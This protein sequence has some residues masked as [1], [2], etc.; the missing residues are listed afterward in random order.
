MGVATA[1]DDHPSRRVLL[2]LLRQGIPRSKIPPFARIPDYRDG[3][4]F[5]DNLVVKTRFRKLF[6]F[7][8]NPLIA[9][10]VQILSNHFD[11]VSKLK[12]KNTAVPQSMLA[13]KRLCDLGFW[14][15][16]EPGDLADALTARQILRDYITEFL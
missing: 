16:D 4:C 12:S 2:H 5:F 15:L 8:T 3:F 13:Y 7:G 6:V 11:H 1:R 14:L 10:C 9:V